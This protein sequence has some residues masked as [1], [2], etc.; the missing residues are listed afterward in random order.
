MV[1][2]HL[3]LAFLTLPLGSLAVTLSGNYTPTYIQV[4]TALPL[5]LSHRIYPI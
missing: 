3:S 4:G 5:P 1:R 2:S